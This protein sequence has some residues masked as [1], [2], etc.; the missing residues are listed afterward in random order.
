VGEQSGPP[1]RALVA[2][3]YQLP[4]LG[5]LLCNIFIRACFAEETTS[6]LVYTENCDT[7]EKRSIMNA[8]RQIQALN[9]RE[10]ENA[11]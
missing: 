3:P 1:V 2:A 9:K 8:I 7:A 6:P 10:L 5:S 11:V 4:Y